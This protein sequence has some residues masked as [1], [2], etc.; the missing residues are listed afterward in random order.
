[1]EMIND[2]VKCKIATYTVTY[3]CVQT[4][5]GFLSETVEN[6]CSLILFPSAQIL[7]IIHFAC[8]TNILRYGQMFKFEVIL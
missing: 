7:Q 5:L 8:T 6:I 1:M 2:K 3:I 4:M